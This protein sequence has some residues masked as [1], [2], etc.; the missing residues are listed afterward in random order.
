[1]ENYQ[2]RAG[3]CQRC[4]ALARCPGHASTD[5]KGR[6]RRWEEEKVKE[7]EEG[8]QRGKAKLIPGVNK[9]GDKQPEAD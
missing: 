4:F 6:K 3:V 8:Q 7:E 5:G 1:M 2:G 9:A